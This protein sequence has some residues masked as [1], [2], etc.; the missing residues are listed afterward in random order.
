MAPFV[1]AGPNG[2]PAGVGVCRHLR[3]PDDALEQVWGPATR[4]ELT[5]A[6]P[7]PDT[8]AALDALLGQW[9]GH[10]AALP[11]ASGAD[12]AAVIN[13]P[14][15]DVSGINALLKHGMQP[16]SVLAVRAAGRLAAT[17][18]LLHHAQL[19]PLAAPF[20]NRMGYRPLW[21][22]WEARPASALR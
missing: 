2:R 13:W 15:R 14:S 4:L 1:A 7:E 11:E 18:T 9:R 20:W 21:T 19:N 8:S 22:T 12:S 17:A 5:P 3:I 10:L 6:L 16:I